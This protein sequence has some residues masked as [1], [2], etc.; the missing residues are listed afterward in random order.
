VDPSP[1]LDRILD[2]E[3]LTAG[4]DEP[5]ASLLIRALAKRVRDIAA[6]AADPESARRQTEVLCR[7]A[8]TT[9]RAVAADPAADKMAILKRLMAEW[10][11]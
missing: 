7:L 9:A 2:D 4:L 8:R 1:L 6:R 11:D 10:P 3:G 5:E